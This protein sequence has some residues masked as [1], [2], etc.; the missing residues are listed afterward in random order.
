MTVKE[1]L[2]RLLR[3]HSKKAVARE[4]HISEETL[5]NILRGDSRPHPGTLRCV[6]HALGIDFGWLADDSK[7]WPPVRIDQSESSH[8]A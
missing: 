2:I 7:G 3:L 1:K 8:A 6:S 5:R 4:A